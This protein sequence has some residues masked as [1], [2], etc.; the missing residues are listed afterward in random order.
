[1]IIVH[2]GKQ[3][4]M[5]YMPIVFRL[6]PNNFPLQ[7]WDG[8]SIYSLCAVHVVRS[9]VTVDQVFVCD[10]IHEVLGGSSYFLFLVIQFQG[11]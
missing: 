2:R 6:F 8:W 11:S 1:M 5:G 7:K 3:W 4:Y 9:Y 10:Y